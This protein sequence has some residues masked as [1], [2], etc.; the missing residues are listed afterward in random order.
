MTVD[1]AFRVRRSFSESLKVQFVTRNT[2]MLKLKVEKNGANTTDQWWYCRISNSWPVIDWLIDWMYSTCHI[3]YSPRTTRRTFFRTPTSNVNCCS[4]LMQ[5]CFP[6]QSRAGLLQERRDH[7]QS[8]PEPALQR[9]DQRIAAHHES[10]QSSE[11]TFC[12]DNNMHP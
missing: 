5:K 7:L 1:W 8:R 6:G 10:P 4:F 2:S 3:V 12:T 11:Y 9:H